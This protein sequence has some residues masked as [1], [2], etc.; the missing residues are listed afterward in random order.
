V[1]IVFHKKERLSSNNL[2]N[3]EEGLK[4][5][6]WQYILYFLI[7]GSIV[8][9]VA[10]LA[11][12]GNQLLTILVGNLPVF[13]LLNL[14]LVYRNGGTTSSITYAKGA[15]ISLPFFIVFVLIT[16]LI[17]PRINTPM[18]I[19]PAMLVYIIPPL[20]YYRR[21]QRVFQE[22]EIAR[23]PAEEGQIASSISPNLEN[24]K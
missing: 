23:K 15:L 5:N 8:A 2:F 21:K 14:I 9:L 24:N 22:S 17:L 11:N 10:Y 6:M 3:S 13:F 12:Q 19:L 7:G 4:R 20:V 16:L 18:A 1:A